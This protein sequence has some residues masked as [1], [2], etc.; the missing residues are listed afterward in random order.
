[1]ALHEAFHNVKFGSFLPVDGLTDISNVSN[2]QTISSE[3]PFRTCRLRRIVHRCSRTLPWN[4][5][6]ITNGRRTSRSC[7]RSTSSGIRRIWRRCYGTIHLRCWAWS[8]CSKRSYHRRHT[9]TCFREMIFGVCVLSVWEGVV[10]TGYWEGSLSRSNG[11]FE[12]ACKTKMV[13][14]GWCVARCG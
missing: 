8:R 10:R 2:P 5:F 11:P 7:W 1:M 3:N 6:C 12:I 9:W 13:L 4:G 14:V